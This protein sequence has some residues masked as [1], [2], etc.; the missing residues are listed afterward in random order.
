MSQIIQASEAK[1]W[2]RLKITGTASSPKKRFVDFEC[3]VSTVAKDD[4][5]IKVWP[6]LDKDP[7]LTEREQFEGKIWF[8]PSDIEKIEL[9]DR[10]E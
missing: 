2:D 8:K 10:E 4:G 9:I 3:M 5:S 1:E 6:M 7:Q